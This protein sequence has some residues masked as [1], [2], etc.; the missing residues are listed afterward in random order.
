MEGVQEG[1]TGSACP[2]HHAG[3]AMLRRA[4]HDDD[5]EWAQSYAVRPA[6]EQYRHRRRPR[7]SWK[8]HHPLLSEIDSDTEVPP[9]VDALG[10]AMRARLAQ[11]RQ[12][13]RRAGQSQVGV[14]AHCLRV[15]G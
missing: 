9:Q 1:P 12:S 5:G 11:L 6:V 7:P 2:H 4:R 10:R 3:H 14:L 8:R 13:L 15:L